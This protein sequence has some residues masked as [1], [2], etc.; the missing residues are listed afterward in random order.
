MHRLGA[1]YIVIREAQNLVYKCIT[2]QL[3]S[4]TPLGF[5]MFNKIEELP[6]QIPLAPECSRTMLPDEWAAK[7]IVRTVPGLVCLRV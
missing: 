2:T 7:K 3:E 5:V 4:P 6:G 1:P